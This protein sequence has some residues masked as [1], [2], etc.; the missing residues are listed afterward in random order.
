MSN[1]KWTF[2]LIPVL[3]LFGWLLFQFTLSSFQI[4]QFAEQLKAVSPKDRGSDTKVVLIS[5]ELDNY[6]WRSI[7]QGARKE[8]KQYG[9]RLDYIGPDRINPS[10]QIKLLD[11]AIAS[12]A[13]AILVQGIN[14]PEYRRL[15]NKAAGLGIPVITIDTDE[16]DSRRLA[17]VGTDNEG[18]GKQMGVLLAKASGEHGDIGVMISNE[19]VEN[20]RL[21]LAGFRSVISRYPNLHIVEIR[22]SNIS[23]LQA[24]Q[25]AQNMLTRYPQIRYM[26]G[27]S[28]LD[29][30][31]I[32]EASERRGAQNLQIFAFDDMA[33]TLK[34]IKDRKIELTIVQ[35]PEE[36]GAKA[37][38]L[39][40]DYLKGSHPQELTYTRV[41]EVHADTSDDKSGDDRR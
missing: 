33:E 1:R 8:A 16:P 21:R 37:I 39:L 27:F 22:S 32:L 24:A 19:R 40:N 26:V 10:E 6:Y 14:D 9:M 11:K 7:E 15:I 17:Y 3:L 5:Q 23:R 18:A 2:I 12:K 41:Y 34:A 20:Q 31:G 13:D 36:M 38:K 35:Q 25:Q 28:A 30:L 4:H 29:G